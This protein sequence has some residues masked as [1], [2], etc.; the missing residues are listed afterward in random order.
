M[1]AANS[2]EVGR[3]PSFAAP[4]PA[5]LNQPGQGSLSGGARSSLPSSPR[6][7]PGASVLTRATNWWAPPGLVW[8]K[9]GPSRPASGA[10]LFNPALAKALISAS[11]D[12]VNLS[13]DELDAFG[14]SSDPCLSYECFVDAGGQFYR[15]VRRLAPL[16]GVDW[17]LR[18]TREEREKRRG[19]SRRVLLSSAPASPRHLRGPS[20][21]PWG[22]GRTPRPRDREDT[23]NIWLKSRPFR[24]SGAPP[25]P[26][27]PRPPS[28]DDT[29]GRSISRSRSSDSS[30]SCDSCS[31][32]PGAPPASPKSP[33]SHSLAESFGMT[34]QSDPSEDNPSPRHYLPRG[35]F[36]TI[37]ESRPTPKPPQACDVPISANRANEHQPREARLSAGEDGAR[38]AGLVPAGDGAGEEGAGDSLFGFLTRDAGAEE[39]RGSRRGKAAA[40][41]QAQLSRCGL[42]LADAASITHAHRARRM[43]HGAEAQVA[44]HGA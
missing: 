37:Y 43:R 4:S 19:V 38:A 2:F 29:G 36:H 34:A 22:P 15:P 16:P 5:R 32:T 31:A 9:I 23:K 39:Q 25:S 11:S 28:P 44:P 33:G 40:R 35:A 21:P 7:L 6:H 42:S 10:E 13:A 41:R 14:A 18:E 24:L 30:A 8:E 20:P 27:H 1:G 3:W 26:R 12:L 17:Y